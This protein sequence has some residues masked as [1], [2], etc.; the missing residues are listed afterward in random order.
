MRRMSVAFGER[1]YPA[2]LAHLAD[3]PARLWLLGGRTDW[4]DRAVAIAIVGSRDATAYG[5]A[6]AG[7]L[8]RELATRGVTVVSGLARGIDR[9]AHQGALAA[10][11]DT[12]AVLGCGV[13]IVYPRATL[14]TRR[15]ILDRGCLVSE[16]PPAS[17]PRR[18]HFPRRN[19]LISG[20]ALGVIVV[21]AAERSGSL[22][23]ARHALEQGR[24]VFAVPG[25]ALAPRSRGPHQ[26]LKQGAKLV[27]TVDDV[28]EEFPEIAARLEPP[29]AGGGLAPSPVLRMLA[30]EPETADG[31]AMRLGR[32][33]TEI[34]REL[35]ELEL[36]GAILRGP[37]GRFLLAPG[38]KG[39]GEPA[40]ERPTGRRVDS[41]W[42]AG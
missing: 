41:P 13:D 18:R 21:E 17:P 29:L 24:E 9:A 36:R 10:G 22:V 5:L 6:V 26:L 28:L 8:G 30:R 31:L 19:R 16:L 2:A 27:E 37:G 23:T 38:G 4:S 42:L 39:G 11:G 40:G 20:L 33:L 12:V 32:Q 7:R 34:N 25:P 3:P 35:T 14:E 15:R 1:G